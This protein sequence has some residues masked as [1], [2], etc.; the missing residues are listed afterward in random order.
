M[1]PHHV[2]VHALGIHRVAAE[3]ARHSADRFSNW[4]FQQGADFRLPSAPDYR[5]GLLAF[6]SFAT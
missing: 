5:T 4:L 1:I 6:R 3:L 2:E